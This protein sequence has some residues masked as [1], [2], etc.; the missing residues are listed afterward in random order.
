MDRIDWIKQQCVVGEKVVDIGSNDGHTFDSWMGRDFVTNVDIDLQDTW[1][2]VRADAQNL[3]FKAKEFDV[4]VLAEVL[5]HVPD[6]VKALKE[7]KRVAKRVVITVPNE[8]KWS[9]IVRPFNPIEKIEE[10]GANRAEEAR[11]GN[12]R[13]IEFYTEDNYAHLWHV[14]FY[15]LETLTADIKKAGF[16]N[17]EITEGDD[18]NFH[19]FL[20]NA[21]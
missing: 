14:R 10:G 15:K 1:N 11:K 13:V 21:K 17:F 6:P 18:S 7:A 5:E 16:T 12:P 20:V 9:E 8:Y 3:P 4:A 19:W 2:F